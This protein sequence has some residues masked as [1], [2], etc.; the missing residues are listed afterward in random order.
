LHDRVAVAGGEF[1]EFALAFD[2]PA[3]A[4]VG[5]GGVAGEAV[6]GALAGTHMQQRLSGRAL[7][8]AFA[9]LLVVVGVW[10]I[11]G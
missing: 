7:S 6:A 3:G 10:L 2:V 4:V 9:G 1:D 8:L 11:A 5:G